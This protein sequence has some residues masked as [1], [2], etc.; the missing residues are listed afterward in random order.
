MGQRNRERRA[1]K[2]RKRAASH[3]PPRFRA[4]PPTD[5]GAAAVALMTAARVTSGGESAA[6]ADCADSLLSTFSPFSA[7]TVEQAADGLLLDVVNAMWSVG[8]QP[9]D[10]HEITRRRLRSGHASLV[11]CIIAEATAR[12]ARAT[13]DA[14]W[15]DQVA[16]LDADADRPVGTTMLGAWA[17][18][19]GAV[20][21][22][23]LTAAIE[24]LAV[25]T[26]LPELPVLVPP[27]GSARAAT[28]KGNASEAQA[29]A[30]VRALLAKAEATGF[31]DEAD[32]L[33]AK[34]QELMARH[35]LQLLV[36]QTAADEREPS[37]A[38]RLWLDAPYAGA[39]AL[40]VDAVADANRCRAVWT[41]WLGFVTVVGD[42]RDL[43]AV[44][45]LVTSLLVQATRAM[46]DP[47]HRATAGRGGGTRSFRQS[48]LVAYASRIGERLKGATADATADIVTE[49][50]LPVLVADSER[51]QQATA[52]LFPELVQKV[53]G[54]SNRW[55]HA[56]GRAAADLARLDVT[57]SVAG[58]ERVAS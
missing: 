7:R 13:V 49:D 29:L 52:E 47:R 19:G 21:V 37:S 43:S 18:A 28:R 3:R 8:W 55:G 10:L 53:M 54:S 20:G 34:A 35:S 36:V 58:G 57:R 51:V 24:L 56:A 6:A 41:E 46:V 31:P 23:A 25:L 27:P 11:A 9:R 48:F 17:G 39:K 14:R 16:E 22:V 42:E 50:L 2:Q 5:V 1:S 33:S 40:L 44:E 45:L 15:L 32:A 12:H 30:R 4:V 26:V 38:R